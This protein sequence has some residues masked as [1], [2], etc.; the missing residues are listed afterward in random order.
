MARIAFVA[1]SKTKAKEVMPAA[2]LYTSPLFKKSLLAALDLADKVYILSAEH[3]V[4][5]LGESVAPYD[6]T[7][8]TMPRDARL[9][10]GA[11]TGEQLTK[12]LRSRDTA[13]MLCGEEYLAPLRPKLDAIGVAL[14]LPLDTLPLGVRLQKL[15]QMNDEAR[16]RSDM[17]RFN[18]YAKRLW[19]AQN[20]GRQIAETSG[21]MEWPQRG[22]YLVLDAGGA[23]TRSGMPRITRVGT[24]A[25]SIGSRTSLWDRL[26]THRGTLAG[27]GSHRSSIFRLHVGRAWMQYAPS[28]LWPA[29]WSEGQSAP[30]D[31]R[32]GEIPLEAQVSRLIGAMRILWLD[33]D[34]E[35]GAASERAY[36]ERNLIGLLSRA[37]LL[38]G[39]EWHGWLGRHAADW[40]IATSGLWNL[41]HIYS[42]PDHECIERFAEAVAHTIG[43]PRAKLEATRGAEQ[44][45]LFQRGG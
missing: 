33:V 29:S 21:R 43:I 26:S 35:P 37:G 39:A 8:K 31:V 34:D 16:L 7:L 25:V 4:L 11:R 13:V 23:A 17:A 32:E 28:A 45:N 42:K 38:W 15:S 2:A 27:G 12:V 14:E 24:H 41:N 36:I 3:G 18:Q 5:D 10:W 40:R 30:R 44:L 1:C 22:V 9:A 20:G 6:T 19:N